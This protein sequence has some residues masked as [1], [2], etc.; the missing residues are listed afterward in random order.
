MDRH[1]SNFCEER[2]FLPDPVFLRFLLHGIARV[3]DKV[4]GVKMT[5]MSPQ[6]I[7]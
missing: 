1:M 6:T 7:E 3:D 2:K 4:I 5:V